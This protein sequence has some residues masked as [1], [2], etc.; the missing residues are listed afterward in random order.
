MKE[1]IDKLISRLEAEQEYQYQK[2]DEAD[3]IEEI[4]VKKARKKWV[5]VMIVQSKSSTNLQR[6][7]RVVGFLVKENCQRISKQYL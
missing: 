6:N 4:T 3:V 5:I 1:F 7:I 2:S